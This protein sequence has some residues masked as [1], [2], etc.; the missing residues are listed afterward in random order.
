M[1]RPCTAMH[2][3][4]LLPLIEVGVGQA[5]LVTT[6]RQNAMAHVQL[7]FRNMSQRGC[8]AE[9]APCLSIP[10]SQVGLWGRRIRS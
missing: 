4:P 2:H 8:V 7:L 5:R 6:T 1:H 3:S 10:V 9:V